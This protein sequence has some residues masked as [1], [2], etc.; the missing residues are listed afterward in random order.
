MNEDRKARE[1][2]KESREKK[3]KE[4]ELL[5]PESCCRSRLK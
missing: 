3:R 4:K 2:K 5:T 1:G